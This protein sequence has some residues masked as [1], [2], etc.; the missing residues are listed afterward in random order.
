[1][2]PPPP[3]VDMWSLIAPLRICAYFHSV[4]GANRQRVRE[5]ESES[6]GREG[7]GRC[8]GKGEEEEEEGV[9]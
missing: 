7:G 8:G 4:A 9:R 1:M 5:G 6:G 3:P 2:L